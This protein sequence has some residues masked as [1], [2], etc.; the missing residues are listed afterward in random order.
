MF[1][2]R[3]LKRTSLRSKN[4]LFSLIYYIDGGQREDDRERVR[5]DDPVNVQA[6]QRVADF[7][8]GE[9]QYSFL[10]AQRVGQHGVVYAL[11]GALESVTCVR[12]LCTKSNVSN[13][14]PVQADFNKLLPLKDELL[15]AAILVN[16]LHA[17]RQRV[18]F[19]SELSRVIKSSG[20]LLVVEWAASF[21]NMGPHPDHALLPGEAVRLF[22]AQ[23]FILGP[24][25]P[26]GSHHYAFV[27]QKS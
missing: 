3:S 14:L 11:D 24:M 23:G 9:G 8:A 1:L 22:R 6:G 26:A 25:L 21:N 10:L 12:G 19:L 27:A 13:V 15:D 17:V 5:V 2:R 7:G 4:I 16:T 20:N 18:Q